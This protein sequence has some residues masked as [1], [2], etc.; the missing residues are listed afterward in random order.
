[1]AMT[2]VQIGIAAALA[3]TGGLGFLA[4]KENAAEWR[5]ELD[6]FT[7]E[8]IAATAIQADND[9]RVNLAAEVAGLQRD[10][11]EMDRLQAEAAALRAKLTAKSV[12]PITRPEPI[13]SPF[14]NRAPRAIVQTPAVYPDELRTQ[15]IAGEVQVGLIVDTNGVVR[16]AFAVKSTQREFEAPSLDAARTWTFDPALVR[17]RLVN[18]HMTIPIVFAAGSTHGTPGLPLPYIPPPVSNWFQP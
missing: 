17:G 9:R 11:G 5:R 15:G 10:D 3:L 16:N 18:T 12:A 8:K 6:A 13:A 2:K 7:Q 14:P 1:M 4:Q